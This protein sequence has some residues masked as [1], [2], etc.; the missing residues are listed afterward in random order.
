MEQSRLTRIRVVTLETV[1][2]GVV[3][4]VTFPLRLR[5]EDRTRLGKKIFHIQYIPVRGCCLR[6]S[7][8][9]GISLGL[10][11]EVFCQPRTCQGVAIWGFLP[12]PGQVRG[13]GLR[14]SAQPGTSLRL[15]SEVFCPTKGCCLRFSAQPGVAVWGFLPNTG[16]VRDCYLRF[17]AQHRNN[18]RVPVRGYLPN[19]GPVPLGKCGNWHAPTCFSTT[20]TA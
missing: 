8:Q 6:F 5:P 11:S 17:S 7:V 3:L 20:T 1:I 13:C 4:T 10:Q 9:P 16:P 19:Q 2:D 18:P 15:L 12:N 14:F